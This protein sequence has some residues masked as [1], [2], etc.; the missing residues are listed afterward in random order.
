MAQFTDLPSEVIL[1]ILEPL[2][3]PDIHAFSSVCRHFDAVT[4]ENS[5]SVYRLAAILH[6]YVSR[7]P[8]L[9]SAELLEQAAQELYGESLNSTP[10][11]LDLCAWASNTFMLY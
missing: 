5:T 7:S 1:Q 2:R 3:I 9:S 10:S 8:F 6:G 11:W 4:K